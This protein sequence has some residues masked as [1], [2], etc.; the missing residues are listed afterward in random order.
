MN[1]AALDAPHAPMLADRMALGSL[2]V[3]QVQVGGKPE[4]PKQRHERH[5]DFYANVGT[6]IRTLR[7]DVPVLFV[8]DM[9]CA[10][11]CLSAAC[12][13]SQKNVCCCCPDT[14]GRHHILSRCAQLPQSPHALSYSSP[15]CSA[16][17]CTAMRRHSL[18][19]MLLLL[20]LLLLGSLCCAC[21]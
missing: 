18:L 10:L 21:R 14:L 17:V 13:T 4:P 2:G 5:D 11:R 6:A 19:P 16:C 12:A 9:D 1:L 7:E 8:R 20:L 15:A 3:L